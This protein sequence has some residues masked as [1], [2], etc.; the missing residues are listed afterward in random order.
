MGVNKRKLQTKVDSDDLD[1]GRKPKLN[2]FF[3]AFV[4]TTIL[5]ACGNGARRV[6]SFACCDCVVV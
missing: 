5:P 6:H 1:L 2:S 4:G 3:F